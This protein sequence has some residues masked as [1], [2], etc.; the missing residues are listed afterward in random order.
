MNTFTNAGGSGSE[1]GG[2]E[3]DTG[4]ASVA[5]GQEEGDVSQPVAKIS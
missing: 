1:P 2:Q 3:E 5:R 4:F